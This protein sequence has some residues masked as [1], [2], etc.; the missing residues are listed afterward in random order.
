MIKYTYKGQKRGR[1]P[2]VSN[3]EIAIYLANNGGV[4]AP[5]NKSSKTLGICHSRLIA[6]R[7]EIYGR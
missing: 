3:R 6:I 2:K 5:T 1:K 4:L 7:K